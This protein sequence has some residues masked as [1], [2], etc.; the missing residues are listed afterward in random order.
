MQP[1][2]ASQ[3][4]ISSSPRKS[5][6]KHFIREEKGNKSFRLIVY[7]GK[8]KKKAFQPVKALIILLSKA[9]I[10]DYGQEKKGEIRIEPKVLHIACSLSIF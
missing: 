7:E 10:H 6:H 3:I 8:K 1:Q 4:C 9:Q 5:Q 2:N